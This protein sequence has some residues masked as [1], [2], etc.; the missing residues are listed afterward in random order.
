MVKLQEV[1]QLQLRNLQ[2]VEMKQRGAAKGT[3]WKQYVFLIVPP[4]TTGT[5]TII[6][7]ARVYT[8]A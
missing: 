8:A 4:F 1:D 7:N 6:F 2:L 3:A 5:T